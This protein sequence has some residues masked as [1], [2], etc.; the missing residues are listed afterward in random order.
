MPNEL[1][2]IE[3]QDLAS[4]FEGRLL[5]TQQDMAPFLCDWRKRWIGKAL[6]VAQPNTPE[7]VAK[8]KG[9]YTGQYLKPVLRGESL[10]KKA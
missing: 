5:I 3:L 9:S 7:D 2:P 6:A 8:V 10:V 1:P 4:A